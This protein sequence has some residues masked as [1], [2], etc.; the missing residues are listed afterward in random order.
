MRRIVDGD[1]NGAAVVDM[2]A[3][4]FSYASMGDFDYNCSVNLTDMGVLSAA[5]Q[6]AKGDVNWN[7]ICDI[8]IPNDRV[9]DLADLLVVANH[10]MQVIE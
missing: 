8:S 6:S 3:Y 7:R 9:I 4:E 1:C 10:W 2:G 5:W